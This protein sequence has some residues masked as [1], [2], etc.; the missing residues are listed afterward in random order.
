MTLS[1]SDRDLQVGGGSMQKYR[2]S[3]H[4]V[5]LFAVLYPLIA[6]TVLVKDWHHGVGEIYPIAPWT[7]FCFVPNQESDF[8]VRLTSIDGQSSAPAPYFESLTQF[9]ENQKIP[10][11][12]IIRDMGALSGNIESEA[13]A[14]QRR[15]F[16]HN[17][18]RWLGREVR[19]ELVRREYDVLNRWRTGDFQ[20]VETIASFHYQADDGP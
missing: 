9:N 7:L 19:Y 14:R 13:F 1:G 3:I 5:V 10:A 18:L 2:A 20:R 16:E 4:G 11:V 8:A 12:S 15:M 17:Y 6:A